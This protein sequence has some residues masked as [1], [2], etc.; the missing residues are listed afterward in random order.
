MFD[1]LFDIPS[2]EFG[3][4]SITL[5]ASLSAGGLAVSRR[6]IYQ[7]FELSESSNETINGFFAGVGVIYGLLVGLVA[8]AAWDNY[9]SVDEIASRE[10]AA[11]AA[12]YRDVSTLEGPTKAELQGPLEDYLHYVIEVA[13]PGHQRGKTPRGG[14]QILSHFHS[15]LAHYHPTSPEQEALHREALAAF[16]KLVEVRRTRLA[17]INSGIPDVFWVA[18]LGGTLATILIAYFFHLASAALHIGLVGIFGGFVGC[19]IFLIFAVD[20]P[21]RGEVSV[22]PDAYLLLLDTLKDLD[23][24]AQATE[25]PRLP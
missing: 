12:L 9:K 20:R 1:W 8:V 3:L 6:W 5:F 2:L 16:N 23:P 19:L 15:V 7:R 11:I 10:S 21:F 18:I 24:E 17:A 13:W 22:Q 25:R 14:S 4:G